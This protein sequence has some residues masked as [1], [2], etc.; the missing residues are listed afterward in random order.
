LLNLVP[1]IGIEPTSYALPI[2]SDCQ[3]ARWNEE[4]CLEKHNDPARSIATKEYSP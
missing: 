1:E 4:M 3:E 2:A